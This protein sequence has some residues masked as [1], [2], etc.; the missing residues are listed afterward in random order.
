MIPLE[1]EWYARRREALLKSPGK[2]HGR[3]VVNGEL[4]K[5]QNNSLLEDII[6]DY[7]GQ[8]KNIPSR[9]N[10]ILLSWHVQGHYGVR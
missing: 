9:H 7:D 1:D 6:E 2:Q 5:Y 8:E 4:Y 3:K 10:S